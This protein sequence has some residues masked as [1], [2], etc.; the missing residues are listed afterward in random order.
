MAKRKVF[1]SGN[2]VV[3]SLSEEAL[4]CLHVAVGEEVSLDLDW[5]RRE[6]V[7]RPVTTLPKGVDAEFARQVAEFIEEY[8]PALDALA[9]E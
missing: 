2:S 4:D 1:R 9:R 5:E 7:L 3:V 6:L 8:R